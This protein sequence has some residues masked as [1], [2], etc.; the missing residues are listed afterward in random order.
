MESKSWRPACNVIN[1]RA[2]LL[3]DF[4]LEPSIPWTGTVDQ[5]YTQFF[6]LKIAPMLSS[7]R[8]WRNFWQ[9]TVPQAAWSDSAIHHAMIAVALTYDTYVYGIDHTAL[10]LDRRKLAVWAFTDQ[11]TTSWEV[12]LIICRLFASM[13]QC[14]DDFETA[15]THMKS[16]E[17][18]L[19]EATESGQHERSDIV[20]LMAATFLGL[21]A[22]SN[23]DP[24]VAKRF[25]LA[26]RK[27]FWELKHMCSEY[28]K[29]LRR[30]FGKNH[31]NIDLPSRGFFSVA[32]TTLNQAIGSAMYP[33]VLRFT[34]EDGVIGVE[35]VR[36]ELAYQNQLISLEDLKD[37]YQP[38]FRALEVHF[39]S[40][41]ASS[42]TL[43]DL[44]HLLKIFVDNY[45]LQAH[46]LEPRMTAGTI[47]PP[48]KI[49][50]CLRKQHLDQD[51]KD[52]KMCLRPVLDR[53]GYGLETGVSRERMEYYHEYVC[54]YRSG[55]MG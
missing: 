52:G 33:E 25:P 49:A 31:D 9:S 48:A 13:A 7:T 15:M 2:A 27:V 38:L 43:S 26:K 11:P 3:S 47:W 6:I 22:D 20:R 18:I 21:S 53:S 44:K 34:T 50:R 41:N 55:F 37:M 51:Q 32:F 19:R 1:R 5:N 10:V 36:A 4:L 35:E 30:M 24:N 16:G 17:R 29:M 39:D 42:N 40:P 14:T 8:K 45:L 28:A 54:E 12:G 46:A 23:D